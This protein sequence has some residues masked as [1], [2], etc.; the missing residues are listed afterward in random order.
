M[1]KLKENNLFPMIIWVLEKNKQARKFY[2]LM[3]GAKSRKDILI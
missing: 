1:Q 2:E 3:G